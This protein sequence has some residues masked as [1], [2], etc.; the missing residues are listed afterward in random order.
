MEST[1]NI[2]SAPDERHSAGSATGAMEPRNNEPN[3][4]FE[5][6]I[7]DFERKFL[8]DCMKGRKGDLRKTWMMKTR[9]RDDVIKSLPSK[10]FHTAC[11]NGNDVTVKW[12]LQ[13]CQGLVDFNFKDRS[14]NNS[15]G[16]IIA[17]GRGHLAVVS[18]L[19]KQPEGIIDVTAKDKN[20]NNG[21]MVACLSK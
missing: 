21:F 19:L 15:T 5:I 14:H 8:E 10:G 3:P 11:Q 1:E 17:C 13:E 4:D 16:F 2:H 7:K 6:R 18:L 20:G 9:S 12:F